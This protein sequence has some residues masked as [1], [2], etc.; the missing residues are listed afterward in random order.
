MELLD[1][2]ASEG[3]FAKNSKIPRGSGLSGSFWS[4]FRPSYGARIV[5]ITLM[6]YLWQEHD[7]GNA[8]LLAPLLL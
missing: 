5:L 6:D 8:F 1:E 4:S 3:G 7:G 2:G